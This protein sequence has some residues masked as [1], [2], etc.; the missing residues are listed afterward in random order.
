[1]LL[2]GTLINISVLSREYKNVSPKRIGL[3]YAFAVLGILPGSMLLS[4]LS[5]GSVLLI[6]G[7]MIVVFSSFLLLGFRLNIKKEKA[8]FPLS[9]HQW[10]FKWFGGLAGP[11]VVLFFANL[12]TDEKRAFRANLVL[13][14]LLINA[15]T[16]PVM[17][18][19]GVL[20]RDSFVL[21]LILLPAL[22][23]GIF[24]GMKLFK[25]VS[26]PLFKKIALCAVFSSGLLAL[27]RGLSV[28]FCFF[29]H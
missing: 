28:C 14:F 29:S 24:S 18:I 15:A 22:F 27:A 8:V 21:A 25:Y 2:H 17:A 3:L 20:V 12:G 16:L 1:M 10:H 7:T 11:P 6:I 23:L 13:Y 9:L 4:R 26:E 5:N 19:R